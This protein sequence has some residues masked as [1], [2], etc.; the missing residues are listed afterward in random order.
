MYARRISTFVLIAAMA[1]TLSARAAF[2]Q[3]WSTDART[4]GMGA[5]GGTGNLADGM[6][7]KNRNYSVIPLPFGLFQVLK[8]RD[9]YDPNSPKFDPIRATEYIASPLHLIIGRDQNNSG[10]VL[11]VNDLR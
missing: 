2:A 6:I 1:V 4:I 7:D 11:L 8:D 9:I 10:Q 5:V 3:N